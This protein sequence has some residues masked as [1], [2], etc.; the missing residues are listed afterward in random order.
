MCAVVLRYVRGAP[1]ADVARDYKLATR[2]KTSEAE[3]KKSSIL[4]KKLKED[5]D[6]WMTR[7]QSEVA[8]LEQWVAKVELSCAQRQHVVNR[9]TKHRHNPLTTVSDAGSAAI[10]YCGWQYALAPIS[11][12]ASLPTGD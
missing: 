7:Y 1:I 12:F 5:L 2:A 8:R 10:A 4:N 3:L 9:R 6:S 11:C